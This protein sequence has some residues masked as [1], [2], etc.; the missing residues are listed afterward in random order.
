LH[1]AVLM[2]LGLG[3][4]LPLCRAVALGLVLATLGAT[5]CH[6]ARSPGSA[7]APLVG[8]LDS[9][10]ATNLVFAPQDSCTQTYSPTVLRDPRGAYYH[11]WAG[12]WRNCAE[13]NV[14]GNDKIFHATSNDLTQWQFDPTPVIAGGLHFNDPT[15]V[16]VPDVG[17]SCGPSVF[18]MYMTG[19]GDDC[20]A[21]GGNKTY[22][23]VSCDGLTWSPP[24]LV[25]GTNNGF[26]AGGAW[27]PSAVQ[28]ADGASLLY[29]YYHTQTGTVLR[30]TV[31]TAANLFA[32]V[33]PPIEV[34]PGF[35]VNVDVARTTSGLFELSYDSGTPFSIGRMISS[36]GV[37]FVEDDSVARIDGTALGYRALTSSE[38]VLD[39]FSYLRFFAWGPEATDQPLS[40]QSWRMS[41]TS[42]R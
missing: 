9:V 1:G 41:R 36:D 5:G 38:L 4:Q 34:V 31:N 19:C 7:I 25:I 35:H 6:D 23:A 8:A 10:V 16:L 21:P 12:G 33:G 30:S 17:A 40:I 22:G 26:D 3:P 18:L 14:D 11:L 39:G 29:L 2:R 37:N 24:T 32:P 28:V 42:A 15:V 13:R 20:F 27:S